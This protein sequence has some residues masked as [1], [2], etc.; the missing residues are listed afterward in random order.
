MLPTLLNKPQPK[1]NYL[2]WEFHESGGKQA[3]RWQNFKAVQ[4]N[5]STKD[6][7]AIELYDIVKDP[8]EK[9]NIAAA[10]AGVVKKM[11][12]FIKQAH[13]KNVDWLLLPS[14]K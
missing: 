12:V 14:E 9:I 2:Y 11:Q 8:E 13:S 4:L 1:H 6:P 3:V 5:V 10:N 7:S